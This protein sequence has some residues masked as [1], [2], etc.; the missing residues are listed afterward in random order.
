ML[1]LA[2][3]VDISHSFD[4]FDEARYFRGESQANTVAEQ[5]AGMRSIP[6]NNNPHTA[7]LTPQLQKEKKITFVPNGQGKTI[8]IQLR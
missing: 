7:V 8:P 3:V 5:Q 4:R 1:F 2:F 6:Q